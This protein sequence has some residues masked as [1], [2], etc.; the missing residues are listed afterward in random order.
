MKQLQQQSARFFALGMIILFYGMSRLP[1]LSATDR[2]DLADSFGF[3]QTELPMPTGFPEQS[4]RTVHPELEQIVGWL[5]AM[6]ASIALND[7]DGDGLPNDICQ[8]EPRID[9][10]VITPAPDTGE[11]YPQFVPVPDGLAYDA[12]KMA[13]I[14]CVPADMNEDGRMDLLVYYW[15]RPP[16]AFLHN[17]TAGD[18]SLNTTSYTAQEL[19]PTG[20]VWNS[21]A[22]TFAD[23]DG[24]GHS[25]LIVTNYFLDDHVVL[26][27]TAD[28][29]TTTHRSM[30]NATNG[31][32]THIFLWESA[33]SGPNPTVS[34]R[35]VTGVLEE[36]V[37]HGWTLAIGAAD[38]NGDLLPELYFANDFGRDRLLHNRSTR[39]ALRFQRLEGEKFLTTPKSKVLG[40]DSFKG[41]GVDFGDVNGDGYLDIYV[42]NIADDFALHE[43]HFLWLSTGE[44]ARMDG[45]IAPY[46]DEGEALGVSRSSWGWES[47]LADFNNDGTLEAVQAT[48]FL[49]GKIDR[50]PELQELALMND[51]M[52]MVPTNWPSFQAGDDLSG[53][54]HNPFFV[55]AADGRFYDLAAE[56]GIDQPYVSRGLAT[57]DVDGDGDLDFAIANQWEPSVFFRNECTDCGTFLGLHLL[58]PV[59]H[60]G[61]LFTYAGHPG[62]ETPGYPAVGATATVSLP[63][64]R[65]LTNF[66]DG[67]NGQ[68]G[69]RSSDLHFGL[70]EL[71]ADATVDVTIRW[72]DRTGE[73]QEI[74][75][76]FTPGWHTVL[77][78]E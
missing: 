53:H 64:G 16:L 29:P 73:I 43:S 23:L 62:R 65:H 31:G 45:G 58:L 20:A 41:M 47:R 77:L 50:W 46:I 57:A 5:S 14:G 10:V 35:H 25:D 37:D 36:M 42:S 15:G 19:L 30:S 12:T 6:G 70:G 24:D 48:G 71:V 8:V 40:H 17:G 60:D 39:G 7:L 78:G 72:R 67:G 32:G 1:A 9:Q 74:E 69:A 44:T 52:V 55:R 75:R 18:T 63:D 34:Y 11:R 38:L 4:M 56:L 59:E 13:P 49:K 68:A 3:Q 33:T 51:E 61:E 54:D 2:T 76:P 66:V 28:N 21:S 22:A 27:R 26:D